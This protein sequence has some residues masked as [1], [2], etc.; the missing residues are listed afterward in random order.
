MKVYNFSEG[1]VD[2]F[3]IVEIC[4]FKIIN[5]CIEEELKYICFW[6]DNSCCKYQMLWFK[7]N[8][9]YY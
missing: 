4:E 6:L 8:E 5:S 7:A 3:F 9:F 2:G 1:I